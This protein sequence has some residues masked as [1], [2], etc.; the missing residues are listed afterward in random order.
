MNSKAEIIMTIIERR[1]CPE[2]IGT[3]AEKSNMIIEK[4]IEIRKGMNRIAKLPMSL[5]SKICQRG[6]EFDNDNRK[7]PFSFS[8]ETELKVKINANNE[9]TKVTLNNKSILPKRKD[10]ALFTVVSLDMVKLPSRDVTIFVGRKYSNPTEN[11]LKKEGA[12]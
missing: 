1:T 3:P 10:G 12:R 6:M 9:S 11:M 2:N 7:V 8:P 4:N 5:A